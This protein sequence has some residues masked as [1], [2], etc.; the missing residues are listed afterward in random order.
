MN[1]TDAVL[2]CIYENDLQ[3]AQAILS[4]VQAPR[5]ADFVNA[6][7]VFLICAGKPGQAIEMLREAL[8][9]NRD[10]D[11]CI[12]LG[13]AYT[14]EKMPSLAQASYSEGMSYEKHKVSVIVPVFNVEPYLKRCIDSIINQKYRNLEMILID[15]GSTDKCG[16][17]CDGYAA[18]DK[19][20]SVIHQSNQGLSAARNSG[21]AVASGDYI[22]FVD[23]D[24]W[25]EPDFIY[26]LLLKSLIYDLDIVKCTF[27]FVHDDPNEDPASVP[28]DRFALLN[29]TEAF[30]DMAKND[31]NAA[32]DKIYKSSL[33]V[34]EKFQVGRLCEDSFFNNK[35]FLKAARFGK[36]DMP[37][38]NYY[39]RSGSI[40]HKTLSFPKLDLLDGLFERAQI[41][42]KIDD[43]LYKLCVDELKNVVFW[44]LVQLDT[45]EDPNE[46]R[47]CRDKITQI[48]RKKDIFPGIIEHK[49][50]EER[51]IKA[52]LI[53]YNCLMKYKP[54]KILVVGHQSEI[55]GDFIE[56]IFRLRDMPLK[57]EHLDSEVDF[58]IMADIKR[59][60]YDCILTTGMWENLNPKNGLKVLSAL[61][62]GTAKYVMWAVPL[63]QT[64]RN[65]E[66]EK[67]Y[68]PSICSLKNQYE[69]YTVRVLNGKLQNASDFFP[70]QKLKIAYLIPHK[71]KTHGQEFRFE[72][73]KE[74]K[75]L[76]HSVYALYKNKD[77]EKGSVSAIPKWAKIDKEVD[78]SGE[79]VIDGESDSEKL[80]DVDIIIDS[81]MINL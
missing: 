16:G 49:I 81:F 51:F 76:G 43:D 28:S 57:L 79:I 55:Y 66:I 48:A 63:L 77:T 7:A 80:K 30:A 38:Y 20:I 53:L 42:R 60:E 62:A 75:K 23:S 50:F 5:N 19:R 71:Q 73:M 61:L 21:L 4:N 45:V 41:C 52:F 13:N 56:S 27:K 9:S 12:S 8:K 70:P 2:K 26:E 37:L 67:E 69:L 11:L 29:R 17:L 18:T 58:N 40:L 33:L 68:Y 39:Q 10:A 22:S 3:K 15:D 78:L 44:F 34:S 25:I 14:A 24:D 47:K 31:D 74:L 64:G 36:Y 32:C 72:Q 46:K 6:E 59:K 54:S 1:F 35:I 65:G